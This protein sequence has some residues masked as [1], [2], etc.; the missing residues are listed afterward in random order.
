MFGLGLPELV[1]VFVIVLL[2]FG[3][4]RIP[5]LGKSIG[6]GIL[7]FKKALKSDNVRDVE[8]IEEEDPKKKS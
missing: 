4:R 8:K 1:I 2:V 7:N 6:E 3:G 5:Q